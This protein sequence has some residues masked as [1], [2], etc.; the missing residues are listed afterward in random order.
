[1][2]KKKKKNLLSPKQYK[3]IKRAFL[4]CQKSKVKRKARLI[5][6]NAQ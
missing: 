5:N 2:K 3:N 4:A 1:M 6:A